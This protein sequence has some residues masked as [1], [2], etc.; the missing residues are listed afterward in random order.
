MTQAK[1]QTRKY[2]D[3]YTDSN[4]KMTLSHFYQY[5]PYKKRKCV[6]CIPYIPIDQVST[7]PYALTFHEWK[8]IMRAYFKYLI[9]YLLSGQVY[10]FSSGIGELVLLKWK[11]AKKKIDIYSTITA[12]MK[13]YNM[14]KA[15]ASAYYKE[16]KE[17]GKYYHNRK[18]DGYKWAVIWRRSGYNVKYLT[19]WG[20]MLLRVGAYKYINEYLKANPNHIQQ[21]S[22]P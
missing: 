22:E 5:Y 4:E 16:H 17:E 12:I 19:L 3:F 7:H 20:L 1:T 18:L 14:T 15:E 11:P 21:I 8:T 6:T 9:L 13:K 2:A 10:R